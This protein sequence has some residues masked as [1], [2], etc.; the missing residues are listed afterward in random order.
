MVL[1]IG[2]GIFLVAILGSRNR[3][4]DVHGGRRVKHS[5][6]VISL[7]ELARY[8]SVP[9]SLIEKLIKNANRNN[10]RA[11]DELE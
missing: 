8:Y 9:A 3:V 6:T 1:Y 4:V 7:H 2:T 10:V 11:L 5:T